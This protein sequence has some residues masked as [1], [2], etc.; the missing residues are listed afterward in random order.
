M[1]HEV[2]K[3]DPRSISINLVFF[4]WYFFLLLIIFFVNKFCNSYT[5]RLLLT[6][7]F[8][9]K[10]NWIKTELIAQDVT[11]PQI[12]QSSVQESNTIPLLIEQPPLSNTY[13]LPSIH[14]SQINR[15]SIKYF[16]V[17]RHVLKENLDICKV[18]PSNP[19]VSKG[20]SKYYSPS[21]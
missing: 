9:F 14:H 5:L 16:P 7:S 8:F 20:C 18:I 6:K 11:N 2:R 12:I 19:S 1:L 15:C 17:N 3:D 4:N 10:P 13:N 21:E